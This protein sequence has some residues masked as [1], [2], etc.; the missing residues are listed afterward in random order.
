MGGTISQKKNRCQKYRHQDGR[1]SASG[2]F[3]ATS[4]AAGGASAASCSAPGNPHDGHAWAAVETCWPHSGQLI[5]GMASKP[6][7]RIAFTATPIPYG[8]T[9]IRAGG[10]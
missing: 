1:T 8:F 6:R 10:F 7:K 3:G 2:P 9:L 5:N 4:G